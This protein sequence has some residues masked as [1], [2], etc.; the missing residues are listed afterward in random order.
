MAFDQL[1]SF[2]GYSGVFDNGANTI[3]NY[4]LTPSEKAYLVTQ[5]SDDG[6]TTWVNVQEEILKTQDSRF[7]SDQP[8][9]RLYRVKF[10]G[11]IG[12]LGVH[13]DSQP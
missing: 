2:A 8:A 1:M 10:Y 6:G 13:F 3:V 9:N 12:T 7:M 11:G 5:H 4:Q